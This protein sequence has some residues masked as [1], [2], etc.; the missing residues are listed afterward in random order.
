MGLLPNLDPDAGPFGVFIGEQVIAITSASIVAGSTALSSSPNCGLWMPDISN[1]PTYEAEFRLLN[2]NS[3]PE[4]RA[5]T[6]AESCYGA[7]STID[8]CNTF[9]NRR[10]VFRKPI[11]AA[12]HSLAM[13]FAYLGITHHTV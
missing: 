6:Y 12:V 8:N 4:F 10:L 5:A 1:I 11:T 7:N 9:Y 2:F 3:D 13:A